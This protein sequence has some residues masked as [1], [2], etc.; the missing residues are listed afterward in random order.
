[1]SLRTHV[2]VFFNKAN[3][4]GETELPKGFLDVDVDQLTKCRQQSIRLKYVNVQRHADTHAYKK[5][6]YASPLSLKY[7]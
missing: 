1:M 6:A 4:S 5:K 7:D 3:S 2:D